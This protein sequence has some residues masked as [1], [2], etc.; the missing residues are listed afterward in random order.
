VAGPI[1]LR[2]GEYDIDI[3]LLAQLP[4]RRDPRQLSRTIPVR[5]E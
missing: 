5:V 4:G 2:P 1:N 3:A